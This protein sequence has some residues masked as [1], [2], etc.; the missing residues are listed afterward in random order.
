MS[1]EGGLYKAL[2]EAS[3]NC[4]TIQILQAATDNGIQNL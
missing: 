1:I 3:I 2:E 4:S